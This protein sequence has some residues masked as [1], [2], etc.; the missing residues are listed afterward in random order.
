MNLSI[1][2]NI[3]YLNE[4]EQKTLHKLINE[5]I[6]GLTRQQSTMLKSAKKEG[7][8]ILTRE[9]I[10]EILG[11]ETTNKSPAHNKPVSKKAFFETIATH[12][13]FKDDDLPPEDMLEITMK[14]LD[15]YGR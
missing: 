14:A 6:K 5:D 7:I 4:I 13:Y 8:D 15:S 11:S 1:A 9:Q 3:S 10:I 2:E 12:S